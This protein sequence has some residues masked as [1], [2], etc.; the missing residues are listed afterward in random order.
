MQI[1]RTA[2]W[3][4]LTAVLVA[5]VAMNW[6]SVPMR[7]WPLDN[8]DYL[9]FEW[10]VGFIAI[11][12]FLLGFLPTWLYHRGVKWRFS[13]RIAT[14][15]NALRSATPTPAQSPAPAPA[16][17]AAPPAAPSTAPATEPLS[18]DPAS[19]D[20]AQPNS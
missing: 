4:I 13:R 2:L 11:I 14:L 6:E 7:F 10:P 1:F 15:E 3:V 17:T 9:L 8:G 16:P 19:A 12:F 20:P 18:A 5:F